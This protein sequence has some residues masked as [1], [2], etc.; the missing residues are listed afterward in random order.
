M[1]EEAAASGDHTIKAS[2]VL[3]FRRQ[4]L[5]QATLI[6]CICLVPPIWFEFE[7]SAFMFD[8]LRKKLKPLTTLLKID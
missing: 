8:Y 4:L 3:L 2:V 7:T 5:A 6:R 1:E